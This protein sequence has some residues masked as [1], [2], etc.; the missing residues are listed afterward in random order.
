M[1]I[2]RRRGTVAPRGWGRSGSRT[3]GRVGELDGQSSDKG[4]CL[5][6]DRLTGTGGHGA[7]AAVMW[8]ENRAGSVSVE[9]TPQP[10]RRQHR[11]FL[12]LIMRDQR[13]RIGHNKLPN[14]RLDHKV[15]YMILRLL[16]Y[17]VLIFCSPL[18]RHL[19]T[20]P[21]EQQRTTRRKDE[22]MAEQ[23]YTATLSRSKGRRSWCVIFR[24]PLRP[25]LDGRPGHRVRKGLGTR[26]EAEAQAI[27][28]RLNV[29]LSDR[30][31]WSPVAR[32]RATH[33]VGAKAA[34][35]FYDG[36]KVMP[37]APW[38]ERD[39]VI[40][41]PGKEEGY[42]RGLL[43]GATRAGKT[44]LL[45]QLIGSDPHNDRF[46]STSAAKTTIYDIEVVLSPGLFRAVASFLGIDQVRS[47]IEECVAAAVSAAMQEKPGHVVLARL[48]EHSEQR[49][50]LSYLLG[51]LPDST[52]EEDFED[53]SDDEDSAMDDAEGVDDHEHDRLKTVLRGFV[54]RIEQVAKDLLVGAA[55]ELE[56]APA[57]LS[58][59][60]YDAF[61][62]VAEKEIASNTQARQL[63]DDILD[64][65]E[66]K[67]A[68]LDG[69]H[70]EYDTAEWPMQWTYETEDR[71]AF[72]R[73]V[74]RLS[75]NYATQFGRLLAPLVCG[76]RVEGPFRPFGPDGDGQP[77]K[78]VL[79]D[80]EGLGHTPASAASLPT[81]VTRQYEA[82]DVIILCDDASQPMQAAPRAVLQSIAASGHEAKLVIAFTHF[83]RVQG[84]NMPT[85]QARRQHVLASLENVITYV[86]SSIGA[87]SGR[88]LRRRLE[89]RTL[90][91]SRMQKRLSSKN[92]LTQASFRKLLSIFEHAVIPPEPTEAIAIYDLANLVLSVQKATQ[93]FQEHWNARLGLVY[94]SGVT[95]EHWARVKAL[96][97]RYAYQS[98][99]QY[100]TLRPV[101]DL[102]R[103]LSERLAPF[104]ASPRGWEPENA[105]N[106]EREAATDAV[107]QAVY[108]KL[109]DLATER[110]FQGYLNEW[111]NAYG[112]RGYGSTRVRA[113][114][115][116][117]I[118][119]SAAPI[120][121]ET[122][123][124]KSVEFLDVVRELF[125]A[126]AEEAGAQVVA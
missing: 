40:P 30:S 50:R 92:K 15:S 115:I 101:A 76:L 4:T 85:A 49:F 20:I 86:D 33:D 120:P 36:I 126:A 78:I 38:L 45:R 112:H 79:A 42:A 109:H 35:F 70:I 32:G 87:D 81:S 75:S 91:F 5:R 96:S 64:E 121:E 73:I 34:S 117:N 12:M 66:S 52:T 72:L 95:S 90:F 7:A 27:V 65:V 123:A 47:H 97:R 60:D 21:L 3:G 93:Q 58:E 31:Y 23:N 29:L 25:R 125:R 113:R 67:F 51:T 105:S 54:R 55:A 122:P 100:D 106:H 46:P 6:Q 62:D 69:G 26:D 102:I 56:V 119:E 11:A 48:L 2:G 24:H 18:R 108:S 1:E 63:V 103:F 68:V 94:K 107:A 104:L 89:E 13:R 99:D 57:S 74:N 10:G 124:T 80:G 16:F 43:V 39:A 98:A 82:V 14:G 8:H 41:L 114:D 83:D 17:V 71:N 61:L 37:R 116:R 19:A 110:L 118:Y 22:T 44:T 111:S 88:R 84:P 59:G 9:P 28:D 53:N 77:P